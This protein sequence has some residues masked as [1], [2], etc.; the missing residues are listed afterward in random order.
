MFILPLFIDKL[1]A[2]YQA[3]SYL[4]VA[5]IQ[6]SLLIIKLHILYLV[7]LEMPVFIILTSW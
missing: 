3:T 6:W 1:I 5:H 2:T 7:L 4:I